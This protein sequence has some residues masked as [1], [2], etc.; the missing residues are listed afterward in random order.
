MPGIPLT[1][2]SAV[3]AG[4]LAT[5]ALAGCASLGP[6]LPAPLPA[7]PAAQW[8]AALPAADP[9]AELKR[10]WQQFNDPLLTAL[11]DA[12]QAA[13]PS[14]AD[15]RSRIE[16]ARAAR[17]AGGA[18]LGPTLDASASATRGRL[19]LG[20]PVG[21]LASAGLQATWEIDLFGGSGARRDAAQA[22]LEGAQAQWHDARISV[23]AETASAYL[24]LR[25]CEA[26]LAQTEFDAASRAETARLTA[27][28]ASAGF[29]APASADLARASAAQGSAT[30]TQQ[31]AQC[32]LAVKSLV[33][34]TAMPEPG[35]RAQLQPGRAQLP[36]P[37]QLGV[38]HVP[39]QALAQRPDLAAAERELAA[40]AADATQARAHRYPRVALAGAIT[41][42]R[43][44]GGAVST[45][46]TLWNIGPLSVSLPLFDGGVR[47]AHAEAAQAAYEAAAT[48][49][50]ASL[51]TAVREV[52]DALV[53]LHST[54]ARGDDARTAAEGFER[55]YRAVE[56][57]YKGGLASL[58]ELEDARRSAVAAQAALI[59]LQR[60]R[61]AAW[62]SLYRALGGGWVADDSQSPGGWTA[63]DPQARSGSSAGDPT[64]PPRS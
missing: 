36:Q 4:A 55:S 24:A 1:H 54:A 5:L 25:A 3:A 16:Q 41:P 33:A 6:A 61:V 35:L 7:T 64:A 56:S 27:L 30:L 22:R 34:L 53:A 38:A 17:V 12:A 10:W 26:Q 11:I 31:R 32:D 23:A 47:R 40:A 44:E 21:T 48:H 59:E 15:A 29:Q 52:E 37:A 8:Q 58:F 13:S 28:A 18:A 14:I 57:R 63:D 49:Y 60:E 50:A 2:R 9:G 62:I 45:S 39:A 42:S 46:G 43:F 51:R 19:E 20:A